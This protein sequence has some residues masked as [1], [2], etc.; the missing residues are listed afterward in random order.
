MKKLKK[1]FHKLQKKYNALVAERSVEQPL[2]AYV[3]MCYQFV[4]IH[5][6]WALYKCVYGYTA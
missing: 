3:P 6:G 5:R 1:K 4:C 2:D